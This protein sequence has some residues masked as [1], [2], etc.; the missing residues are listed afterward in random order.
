[1]RPGVGGVLEALANT[2]DLVESVWSL[3]FEPVEQRRAN[4]A[5]TGEHAHALEREVVQRSRGAGQRGL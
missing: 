4:E 3:G 1:M 2:A 5:V